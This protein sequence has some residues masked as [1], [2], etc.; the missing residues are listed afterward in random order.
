[1][2]LTEDEQARYARLLSIPGF[3]TITQES[4]AAARVH[5]VGAGEVAG[6]A[7]LYLAGA[8]VGSL[9]LDD[10][11]DVAPEDGS[12]WLYSADQVGEPRIYA[13]A[14]SLKSAGAST[15]AR[16]YAT[17]AQPSATLVCGGPL[18]TAR[19]AAERARQAGLPHVVA[20]ADGE[21]GEVVCVPPGAPCYACASRP[22]MGVPAR[23]GSAAAVGALGALEL[24]LIIVGAVA[25][26][27]GRRI[28]LAQ[29]TLQ[30]RATTRVPGCACGQ[31]RTP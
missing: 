30:M 16:P 5:V 9:L 3:S 24:I 25:G 14:A 27:G 13:A 6:P 23:A 2:A 29:G 12:A 19:E 31:G 18:G 21:G 17:G 20:M 15:R 4:L 22:G 11:L 1:M 8:G 10:A 26:P 28:E 7:L